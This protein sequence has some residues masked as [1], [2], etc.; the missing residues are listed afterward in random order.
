MTQEIN[1]TG[2]RYVPSQKGQIEAEHLHRY[3]IARQLVKGKTVLDIASGEGYG[4]ALI[5]E[6]AEKVI[7]VDIDCEAVTH[8]NNKY[9]ADNLEFR[10]GSCANIPVDDASIDIVI[11]FETIEHHNQ[12]EKMMQEFLRVLKADGLLLISSPN[13]LEYSDAN[14]Y[15]NP[16]HIKELYK[17]QFEKLL[18]NNFRNTDI[19]G[20]KM[21]YGSGI[22]ADKNERQFSLFY[23][24]LDKIKL[25]KNL[26]RPQYDIALASN[27]SLPKIENSFYERPVDD[28]DTVIQLREL[29]VTSEE[30]VEPLNQ[31]ISERDDQID[32]LNRALSERDDQIDILNRVLSERDTQID[33]LNQTAALLEVK[34]K[35]ILQTVTDLKYSN[36]LLRI[37]Q[38]LISLREHFTRIYKLPDYVNSR[39]KLYHG[40]RKLKQCPLFDPEWYL[41][42]NPDV[43]QAN[44]NPLWH[45][46]VNGWKE[47]RRP[48]PEFDSD[49]YRARYPDIAGLDQP[50]LLHYWL[51]GRQEGRYFNSLLDLEWLQGEKHSW[52]ESQQICPEVKH[53]ATDS[54]LYTQDT[55]YISV[56]IPTY[57]RIKLLPRIIDSWRKV[58]VC[59]AFSY[60]IIFSDDE[61]SDET[62][63]YLESVKD[64]PLRVLRNVHGGASSARNAAIQAACGERLLIIGDD[65]FPDQE[66]LNI[67]AGLAQQMGSKV[68]ILGTVDWHD[69]LEVNHLMQHITEIGN[70]Q[71]SYNRL[72]D[73]SFIDFRHFYT[74]N[75]SIDRRLL[76]EEKV[77]FDERFNEYGFEDIELGYR[78][79]L[80]GIKTYFTT[81]AKGLHYHPYTLAGFCRRQT[82][83]GRMAV[84]FCNMHPGIDYILGI[85]SL[86]V[87]ARENQKSS[88]QDALW[89]SRIDILINRCDKYEQIV[90]ILPPDESPVIRQCLS[91]LYSLL[92]RAM[93]EYGVLSKLDNY[94]SALTV[95][96][97]FHFEGAWDSYWT[98]LAQNNDKPNE[99]NI[100]EIYTL[101]R[102]IN[103][104]ESADLLNRTEQ[105][106][107]FH[108]LML[109]KALSSSNNLASI[110]KKIYMHNIKRAFYYLINNPRYLAHRAKIAF[111]HIESR[112]NSMSI[113]SPYVKNV[114][115]AVPAL[116]I[117]SD[118][119]NRNQIIASFNIVFGGAGHV[120]ERLND[121]LLVP[122]L[123]DGK[124]GEPIKLSTTEATVF[125]WPT[126]ACTLPMMKLLLNAYMALVENGL[127]VAIISNSLTRGLSI[128]VAELRD[129]ML[130]SVDI[131]KEVF[132]GELGNVHLKGKV[133]RLLPANDIVKVWKLDELIGAPMVIDKDDFFT[134][135]TLC[136]PAS[137][138]YED[139]YLPPRLKC[140]QVV[141]VFPIFLAVGGV[142]RNT[143]EIM[144]KLNDK[145]DFVV[146]TMERLRPEQGSLAAQAIEVAAMVIEMAEIVPQSHY[147][148]V[149]E[150]MKK[151]MQPDIVWVCNGSPWFCD[152]AIKIRQVFHNVPIID[153][154]VY[155]TEQGWIN[156]YAEKGIQSFDHFIA[157][158]KKI[159]ERFL[160]DFDISP[161]RTHMI[162]PVIDAARIWKVKKTSPNKAILKSKFGLPDN[163]KIYVFVGRLS[164]Q[165][166]P[167]EFLKLVKYRSKFSDEYFV[168]LGDGEL[169]SVVD[170]FVKKNSL[171]NVKRISYIE[172]VPEF[173]DICSGIIFTSV[174][175]GLPIAMLEALSMGVPVFST[176]VGDVSVVLEEYGGGAVIPVTYTEEQIYTA[177]TSWLSLSNKYVENLTEREH[178]ILERFSSENISKQYDACWNKAMIK[179][180]TNV[181]HH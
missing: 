95:S 126:S 141:F 88:D 128:A 64:L 172:N 93:Y 179:Y 79:A 133:L 34:I 10:Q 121:N 157:I 154:E 136:L 48:G 111:L 171:D 86:S 65:I 3:Y 129:H 132:N 27:V 143:I 174:Y 89:Q 104:G 66:I 4:S 51:H 17:E 5:S 105:K 100:D 152:N 90:A 76:L 167:I 108:E 16:F 109:V 6:R 156:R 74:C 120:F 53:L 78:L 20:Q 30:Q 137:V 21:F 46:L 62:V 158:N 24:E 84:V 73:N 60:E 55:V 112:K 159:E 56:I 99:L 165:K 127:S 166:R 63:K 142:E 19:L 125:F 42:H 163:K 151:S 177:F 82:S 153:Q 32:I 29:L 52:K 117:E 146:V 38:P 2:E 50:P 149:L 87:R 23:D 102:Y 140:K 138:R 164:E 98:L 150:R 39:K 59:T 57:N 7:G 45:Y 81:L 18:K 40:Y 25:S 44:I 168:M 103:T 72:K 97:S 175:E 134:S 155:D 13:K 144:R 28:N 80:R 69:E 115:K 139:S 47:N 114:K 145:Y 26:V 41:A 116:I 83:A 49:Y 101:N 58:D 162:Y 12:H 75:I 123:K 71:F 70:E 118:N 61:S 67:H 176:D 37:T 33:T 43:S 119:K 36:G 169:S 15:S 148:R 161:E 22:I 135:D 8:A 91:T 122:L 173:F 94:P 14:N 160:R 107:I 31:S 110:K 54:L 96:M 180:N 113:L 178:E 85:A 35:N 130:F 181:G 1:F 11:S 147:L 131:A 124:Q 77:I 68:A 9:I 92:F 106:N 170:D